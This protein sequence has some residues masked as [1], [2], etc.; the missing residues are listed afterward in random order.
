MSWELF[1]TQEKVQ[2]FF[3]LQSA[4]CRNLWTFSHCFEMPT[5]CFQ[6][7]SILGT[8]PEISPNKEKNVSV[9]RECWTHQSFG[10]SR[11]RACRAAAAGSTFPRRV[12]NSWRGDRRSC[13]TRAQQNRPDGTTRESGTPSPMASLPELLPGC[14]LLECLRERDGRRWRDY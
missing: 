10:W 5:H 2:T 7:S 8:L 14:T 12:P 11:C 6:Q 3:S 4:K 1:Q 9:R 13:R